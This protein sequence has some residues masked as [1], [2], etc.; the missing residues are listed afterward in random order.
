MKVLFR[1]VLTLLVLFIIVC[2]AAIW[3]IS[4]DKKLDLNY[5]DIDIEAKTMQ[6]LKTKKPETT[7][8]G[9]ELNELAKKELLKHLGD[10]P[11]QITITGAEF[12]FSGQEVTADINGKWNGLIPFGAELTFNMEANGSIL[13][14]HHESTR[15]KSIQVPATMLSLGSIEV[16]LKDQL[17]DMLTVDHIEFLQDGAKL[18]FKINWRSLPLRLL[19]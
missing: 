13:E 2:G 14:L 17:P 9:S 8:S 16:H 5:Q 6:M 12:H 19:K 15:I 18:K 1:I 7:L 10:I 4:P 11:Q 3:Y